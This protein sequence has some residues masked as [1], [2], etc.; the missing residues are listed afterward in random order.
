MHNMLKFQVIIPRIALFYPKKRKQTK[1]Q[2]SQIMIFTKNASLKIY[3]SPQFSILFFNILTADILD[4]YY[5]KLVSILRK[6]HILIFNF[7]FQKFI[8]NMLYIL[9]LV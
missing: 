6:F 4:Y 3:Q 1:V 9:L 2:S 8:F 5:V 7:N